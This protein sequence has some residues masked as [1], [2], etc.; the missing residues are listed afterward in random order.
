M[1]NIKGCSKLLTAFLNL[2]DNLEQAVQAQFL[3]GLLV[4]VLQVVRYLV[5]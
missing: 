3:N 5:L 4:N 2:A 1:I